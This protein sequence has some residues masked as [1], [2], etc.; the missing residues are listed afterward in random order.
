[1]QLLLLLLFLLEMEA[2]Q[3]IKKSDLYEK[4]NLLFVYFSDRY[5]LIKR[6]Q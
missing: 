4:I 2:A 1:M 6:R 3:L 5:L